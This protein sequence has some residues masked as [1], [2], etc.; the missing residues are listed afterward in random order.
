MLDMA[1]LSDVTLQYRHVMD[2]G[3]ESVD[4]LEMLL[5]RFGQRLRYVLVCNELRGDDFGQ[6]ERSG[7]LESTSRLG[8]RVVYLRHLHDSVV[9]K[10]DAGNACSWAARHVIGAERPGLGAYCGL[11]PLAFPG[12]WVAALSVDTSAA[13]GSRDD[14]VASATSVVNCGGTA[15]ILFSRM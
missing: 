13:A 14:L 6:L 8:A 2:A 15:S 3:R 10:I 7:Q 5:D 12:D 11:P 9:R 1:N 4:L